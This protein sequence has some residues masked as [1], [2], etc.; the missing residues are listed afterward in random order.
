MLLP[1]IVFGNVEHGDRIAEAAGT[2]FN[3]GVDP[4]ISRVTPQG[5]L[6]GG[7]L[8]SYW[9]GFNGS[10]SMHTA[11]FHPRW[12]NRVML[13]VCFDYPFNQLRVRKIFGQVP[14]DNDKA[15]RF[16]EHLGFKVEGKISDVYPDGDMILMSMYR[17]DCRFLNRGLL[18]G[19]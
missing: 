4:V 19:R 9:T 8:L 3:W 16:N 5:E 7:V 2:T 15:L 12:V 1:N 13:W 17:A 11:G 10:V 18:D 6:M 14:E